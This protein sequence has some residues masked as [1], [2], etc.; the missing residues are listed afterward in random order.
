MFFFSLPSKLG[1]NFIFDISLTRSALIDVV[2][3]REKEKFLKITQRNLKTRISHLI[4]FYFFLKETI[5]TKL[6]NL[7]LRSSEERK[8]NRHDRR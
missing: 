4:M 1:L 6:K 8:V 3:I 2:K 5:F 7:S